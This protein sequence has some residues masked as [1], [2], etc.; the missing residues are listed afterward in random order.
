MLITL[1]T[2][3]G[4]HGGFRHGEIDRFHFSY[5]GSHTGFVSHFLKHKS[6]GQRLIF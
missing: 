5:L 2:I 6:T 1:I 3:L 4:T